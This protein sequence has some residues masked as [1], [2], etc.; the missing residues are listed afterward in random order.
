MIRFS[1]PSSSR[2]LLT[3][4]R[5]MNSITSEVIGT[6]PS[7]A[8][9]RRIAMRVSRSG[10]VRSAMR[11]HSKRLRRRSSS[12]MICFGGRSEL[13]TI[14]LPSSWIALNVWK[15]SSWVRSLSAMNWMSSMRRRSI[16]R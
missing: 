10:A 11:P 9:A 4:L 13:R 14:C 7:S 3:T 2:M 1:A 16:R 8:L 6:A 5:A 12:V 15:N